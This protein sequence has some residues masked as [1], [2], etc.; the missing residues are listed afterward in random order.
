MYAIAQDF[1]APNLL[2]AGTEFG[3]YFT[4]DG[5]QR[6]IQLKGGMP[7]TQVRDLELQKRESDVVMATFGRGFW[8]LDDYSAL[9]EVSAQSMG[10][11]AR[12]YPTRAQ[13]YQ[14][15][16][17]G[18][19]QDGSAGLSTLGGNYTFPNPPAGAAIIRILMQSS[20]TGADGSNCD[21]INWATVPDQVTAIATGQVSATI[22]EL[23]QGG[24]ATASRRG[25]P[26]NCGAWAGN[27]G[28]LAFP[29]LG[30]DQVLPIVG[31]QDKANV[32]RLQD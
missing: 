13:A 29:V 26:L 11:E 27:A 12:L 8:I 17:W 22:T 31:T 9:R 23:R 3:L 30:M 28:S 5:G 24:N 7:P 6:W 25:E 21:T 32:T 4:V 2:F 20:D 10:E 16:P 1:I 18:V 19:A 14:I 15:N